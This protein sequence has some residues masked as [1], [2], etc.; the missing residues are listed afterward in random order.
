MK[1]EQ[2][3]IGREMERNDLGTS[4]RAAEGNQEKSVELTNIKKI[5]LL[6]N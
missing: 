1:S 2:I 5:L 3:M 6:I 4:C